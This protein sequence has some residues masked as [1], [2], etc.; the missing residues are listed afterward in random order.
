[1]VRTGSGRDKTDGRPRIPQSHSCL[2][3]RPHRHQYP[4]GQPHQNRRGQKP[5]GR[6]IHG[7][8]TQL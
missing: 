1:M 2:M 4:R 3:P 8:Q 7:R 5:H 6:T